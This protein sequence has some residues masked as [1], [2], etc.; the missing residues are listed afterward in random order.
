MSLS[1]YLRSDGQ[2]F[3]VF[4]PY[5]PQIRFCCHNESTCNEITIRENFIPDNFKSHDLDL[6]EFSDF[7]IILG[8]PKCTLAEQK[9][10]NASIVS[11]DIK[12]LIVFG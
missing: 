5:Y 10:E 1:V 3:D 6:S 7:K 4:D 9:F 8:S 12:K 2:E 11:C